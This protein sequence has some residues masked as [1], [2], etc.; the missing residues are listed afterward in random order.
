MMPIAGIAG[1]LSTLAGR[2]HPLGVGPLMFE[3]A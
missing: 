1:M 3:A 2:T